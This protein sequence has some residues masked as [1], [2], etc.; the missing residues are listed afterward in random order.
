MMKEHRKRHDPNHRFVCTHEGCHK[1]YAMSNDLNIHINSDH[2]NI[3]FHCDWPGCEY[4]TGKKMLLKGHMMTVHS[5]ERNFPC[6]WARM[7]Q[8]IQNEETFDGTY[9]HS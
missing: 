9:G 1:S 2:L 4:S 7:W 5:E 3:K 8:I 6:D